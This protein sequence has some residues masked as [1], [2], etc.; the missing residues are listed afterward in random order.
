MSTPRRRL[1]AA[2]RRERIERAATEVFAERG[3]GGAS[4]SAIAERAGISVPVLY[5]HFASKLELHRWLLE[6]TRNELLELWQREFFTDEPAAV[7]IP[8]ALHAWAGYVESHP[9]AARMFFRDTSG[10]PEAEAVHREIQAQ[11]RVALGVVLGRE[12]GAEHL[13][14]QVRLE[15]AA[16]V[17]RAGLSGLAVWWSEHPGVAREE[18]VAVAL[19]VVWTGFERT[20]DADAGRSG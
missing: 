2:E 8:R 5:D 12:P 9:Y 19:G 16:E 1:S 14:G 6:H 20:L 13:G 4:T 15:M 10:D 18:I 7:R 11:A 3:Y 17:L